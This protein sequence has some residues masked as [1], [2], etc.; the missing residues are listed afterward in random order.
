MTRKAI[1][2]VAA[3]ALL[4]VAAAFVAQGQRRSELSFASSPLPKDDDEKRILTVLEALE[5]SGRQYQSV[6]REDG[7]LLR[8]LAETSN[9]QHV[10][11]LGT[12]SGY[13][14]IWFCLA[15]RKTGGKLTTYEIDPERIA[16]ARGNFEKAG[17]SDRVTV[18]EGDAHE[19]VTKL[20]E[21][22][23]I[24]FLDADKEGYIDYL[25]K[26]LPL[27]RPGGLV[28]AH[29]MNRSQADPRY[30]EAIT[31]NPALETLFLNMDGTGVG[32]TLKKR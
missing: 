22:I 31:T 27:V 32:V 20:K 28:I 16:V 26:L 10:V 23:D 8:L 6:P 3:V 21:P 2:A 17:V 12:S 4:G 13:S 15:L 24:I 25:N 14:G 7:R 1:I 9:A 19:Q 18:V 5:P 30:V 29:N 11:E